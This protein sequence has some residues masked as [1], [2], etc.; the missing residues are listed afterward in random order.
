MIQTHWPLPVLEGTGGPNVFSANNRA[1]REPDVSPHFWHEVR[2]SQVKHAGEL[3][4]NL[5]PDVF[6]DI[7]NEL[8]LPSWPGF[9]RSMVGD[10]ISG[11][12][13]FNSFKSQTDGAE[14]TSQYPV[15]C[16]NSQANIMPPRHL[17][18][19]PHPVHLSFCCCTLT[20]RKHQG[21][22]I[23]RLQQELDRSLLM[24]WPQVSKIVQSTNNIVQ[25]LYAT[26]L[27]KVSCL[28]L[29]R[30]DLRQPLV[31]KHTWI[32]IPAQ[33]TAASTHRNLR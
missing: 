19:D 17:V 16:L 24:A 22:E 23:H 2:S 1:L 27:N 31:I 18:E 10:Y 12:S 32:W 9:P 29:L 26:F 7:R 33:T 5:I 21:A 20:A 11:R 13:M 30:K 6:A 8:A 14:G 25:M 3:M 15:S 28:E 4:A